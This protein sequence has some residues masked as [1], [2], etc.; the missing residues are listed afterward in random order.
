MSTAVSTI[1]SQDRL[2]TNGG[3]SLAHVSMDTGHPINDPITSTHAAI[4]RA[5]R[6]Y[7]VC[8]IRSQTPCYMTGCV[9]WSVARRR[10]W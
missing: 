7:P 4:V 2:N 1:A 6:T 3:S 9:P 8:C 10:R 5:L